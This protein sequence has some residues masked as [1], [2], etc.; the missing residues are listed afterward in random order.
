MASSYL[1][2][3]KF[4]LIPVRAED[5]PGYMDLT[6]KEK[7]M[8]KSFDLAYDDPCIEKII[9]G[10]KNFKSSKK[11]CCSHPPK[12]V[13]YITFKDRDGIET[14]NRV[15]I[16]RENLEESPNDEDSEGEGEFWGASVTN[17]KN[18]PIMLDNEQRKR[19]NKVMN[20]SLSDH[21]EVSEYDDNE[22]EAGRKNKKVYVLVRSS[23]KK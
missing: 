18:W 15:I 23:N 3:K 9:C 2:L 7:F 19:T 16:N 11:I 1:N 13:V 8:H 5:F 4:F 22:R 6:V 17:K 21:D 20:V 12:K 14:K 10:H